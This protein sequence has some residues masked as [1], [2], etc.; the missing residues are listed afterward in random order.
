MCG[1]VE[2]EKVA[3]ETYCRATFLKGKL[4]Q[5]DSLI[6]CNSKLNARTIT[7]ISLANN[8][9]LSDVILAFMFP[10]L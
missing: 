3:F 6:I 4:L 5:T 7:Q 8:Y 10:F 1:G 9:V 2:R